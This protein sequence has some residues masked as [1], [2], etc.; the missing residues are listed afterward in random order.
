[1]RGLNGTLEDLDTFLMSRPMSPIL[2]CRSRRETPL[3]SKNTLTAK[4]PQ[5]HGGMLETWRIYPAEDVAFDE[6]NVNMDDA[7]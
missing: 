6:V 7:L 1:M 4:L 5:S 2:S 3:S